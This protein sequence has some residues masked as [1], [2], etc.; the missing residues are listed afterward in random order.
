MSLV[1]SIPGCVRLGEG[2]PGSDRLA[3]FDAISIKIHD[4]PRQRLSNQARRVGGQVVV[5]LHAMQIDPTA[6]VEDFS[7]VCSLLEGAIYE[8]QFALVSHA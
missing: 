8:Y 1:D 5:W 6:T 4:D 2:T 7:A 3:I